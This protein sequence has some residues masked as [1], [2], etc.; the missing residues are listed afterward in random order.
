MNNAFFSKNSLADRDL[1]NRNSLINRSLLKRYFNLELKYHHS[2]NFDFLT[3]LQKV[4]FNL[5]L[6]PVLTFSL[7]YLFQFVAKKLWN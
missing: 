7:K 5:V 6:D 2:G 3:A 4:N 1:G